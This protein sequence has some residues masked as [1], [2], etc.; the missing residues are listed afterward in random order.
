MTEG[1][2]DVYFD[3]IVARSIDEVHRKLH[4]V[5]FA[6]VEATGDHRLDEVVLCSTSH[7][8]SCRTSIRAVWIL[9]LVVVE[10]H[11]EPRVVV[12]EADVAHAGDVATVR[13]HRKIC[14]CTSCERAIGPSAVGISRG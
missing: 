3:H 5:G 8:C 10:E 12:F 14:A 11:P 7:G 9:V 13:G 4:D 2:V 1:T 6:A